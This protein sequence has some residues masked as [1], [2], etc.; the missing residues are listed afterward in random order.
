MDF[1]S[2]GTV[3]YYCNYD[4]VLEIIEVE[5]QVFEKE[6]DVSPE[7]DIDTLLL[8][9]YFNDP[10]SH[11]LDEIIPSSD[12]D[13]DIF[14]S[15]LNQS[16]NPLPQQQNDIQIQTS[17]TRRKKLVH[18]SFESCF[19]QYKAAWDSGDPMDCTTRMGKLFRRRFRVPWEIYLNIY[20]DTKADWERYNQM[21]PFSLKLLVFLRWLAIGATFD[22]L[23]ELSN[24]G[25]E[26]CRIFCLDFNLYFALKYK[27]KHIKLPVTTNEIRHVMG[28][29]EMNGLPGCMGS[30]DG[31]KQ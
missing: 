16:C 19:G 27:A 17:N 23:F 22:Q 4:G 21:H 10:T 3:P 30:V 31:G 15:L 28:L 2:P 12:V 18:A 5:E 29:Y 14:S 6:D 20:E 11:I 8:E 1:N 7:I 25:E 9:P 26:T 24:I 13:D